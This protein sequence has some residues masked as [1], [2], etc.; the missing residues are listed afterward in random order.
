MAGVLCNC[1]THL[2]DAFISLPHREWTIEDLVA[3]P[4]GYK[5]RR[6][7][8]A[9]SSEVIEGMQRA[10]QVMR[11]G[12]VTH[13]V[14]F[15]EGG[16]AGVM[17]LEEALGH[18][19]DATGC[20]LARPRGHRYDAG[21]LDMLLERADGIGVSSISDWPR[22][23]LEQVAAHTRRHGKMFALH[24]SEAVRENIDGVLSLEPSF[25][26]HLCRASDGD[27][28]AVAD[29][30]VP[31]V[32][33]PRANAFFGLRPPVERMLELGVPVM[34]GTDNAMLV[35]P[36]MRAE[37]T[38]LREHFDVSPGDVQAMTAANPRKYL[39]VGGNIHQRAGGNP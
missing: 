20:I 24:A 6:L 14:D 28:Q 16:L 8:R 13:F 23:I 30:G 18:M 2:G 19:D 7:R 21:E 34:L 36:D 25:L 10:L 26:V 31:V 38:Y 15:R 17:L 37:I 12:G 4:D 1:H 33:C 27:L 11:D 35:L 32:V 3:P 29:A 9:D 22:E 5:H 39:N